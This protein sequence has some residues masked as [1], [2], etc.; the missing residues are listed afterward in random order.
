MSS[1]D[2]AREYMGSWFI[3]LPDMWVRATNRVI[4]DDAVAGE[5]GFTGINTGPLA[6]GGQEIPAT[7]KAVTGRGCYFVKARDGK[8]VEFH[9][10]PDALGLM[11][12]LGLLPT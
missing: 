2:E 8:I 3:A 1:R 9:S 12:Q 4:G 7:G 10:H 5:V 11:M 6:M